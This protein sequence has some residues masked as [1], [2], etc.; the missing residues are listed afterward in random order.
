MFNNYKKQTKK[1]I[2]F[3]TKHLS[4]DVWSY[5]TSSD[6]YFDLYCTSWENFSSKRVYIKMNTIS[7]TIALSITVDFVALYVCNTATN[8]DI[9]TYKR[10]IRE[11]SANKL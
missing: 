3:T 6:S 5:A 11:L 1:L 8:R 10:L 7:K 4:K 9:R 2:K